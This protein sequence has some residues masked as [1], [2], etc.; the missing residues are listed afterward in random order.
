MESIVFDLE[1]IPQR[2]PLTPTQEI[3]LNKKL[4]RHFSWGKERTIEEEE[5]A[6]NMVMAINPFLGEIVCIGLLKHNDVGQYDILSLTGTEEDILEHFWK[7]IRNFRGLFISYNGLGFDTHYILKRSMIHKVA[8]TC[9]NFL[10][11]RRYQ[12][13]PH[14]D[15]LQVLADWSPSNYYTLNLAC[16]SLGVKSPKKGDIRAENV[17]EAFAAGRIDEIA[18]YCERDLLA[19]YQIYTIVKQYCPVKT[20]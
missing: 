13:Y 14:F 10:N 9:N 2:A 3:E 12:R 4:D 5:K 17:A 8:S 11:T 19:T 1:C 18:K 20:Y 6:K 15:V 7:T 16:E